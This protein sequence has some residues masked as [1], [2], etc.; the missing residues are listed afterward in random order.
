MVRKLIPIFLLF[1]IYAFRAP[2]GGEPWK[3]PRSADALVDPL[4]NDPKAVAKGKKIFESL[5]WNCHGMG[6]SGDGPNASVL[7]VKPA[8]LGSS[9][10]QAQSNGAL[11]WKI[12]HGRGEMASYEQVISREQRW[13]VAHYIRTFGP[14]KPK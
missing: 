1:V 12:T 11:Y 2:G 5:C 6:G 10:V 14:A 13:A 3:A 8:D 4:A 7:T 9:T